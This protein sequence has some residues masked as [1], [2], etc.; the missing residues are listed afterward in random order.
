MNVCF[1][2]ASEMRD[3]IKPYD[4]KKALDDL[5]TGD[6]GKLWT[7]ASR[8]RNYW[9]WEVYEIMMKGE[10]DYRLVGEPLDILARTFRDKP[11]LYWEFLTEYGIIPLP[12]IMADR[13]D[14]SL[15]EAVELLTPVNPPGDIV[16]GFEK[17]YNNERYSYAIKQL[18]QQLDLDA[19][20]GYDEMLA[21]ALY[22]KGRSF[23]PR[24][25]GYLVHEVN[26]DK[27]FENKKPMVYGVNRWLWRT[28]G[29][30]GD[31]LQPNGVGAEFAEEESIFGAVSKAAGY[32]SA[33]FDA[34]GRTIEQGY[35]K[36]VLPTAAL[37]D[38]AQ[39]T[40]K[41]WMKTLNGVKFAFA[42]GAPL[43]RDLENGTVSMD[44]IEDIVVEGVKT[45]ASQVGS[46]IAVEYTLKIIFKP[47]SPYGFAYFVVATI[48]NVVYGI[49]LDKILAELADMILEYLHTDF[50]DDVMH[51]DEWRQVFHVRDMEAGIRMD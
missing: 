13:R 44:T 51:F 45:G 6:I 8:N 10:Q 23:L 26:P 47:G 41:T 12:D 40:T 37:V 18:R 9:D 11:E 39:G 25:E 49:E 7:W 27:L 20:G 33:P 36:P 17:S 14:L 42:M 4:Y 3:V 31:D 24:R 5:D 46:G 48:L 38:D 43:V 50:V 29:L 16:F 30:D 2:R 28:F 35:L 32:A 21:T 1:V 19:E 22:E 34:M 15:S